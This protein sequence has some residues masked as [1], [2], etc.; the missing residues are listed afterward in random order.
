MKLAYRPIFLTTT[1]LDNKE[2]YEYKNV[3]SRGDVELATA[4]HRTVSGRG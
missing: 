3:M 2:G 4:S 1:Y